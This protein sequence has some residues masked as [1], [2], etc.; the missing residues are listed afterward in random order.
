MS[1]PALQEKEGKKAARQ[2]ELAEIFKEA[3]PEMDL[4]KVKCIK[5]T[6]VD[7]AAHIAS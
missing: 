5:G 1:F 3:G 4:S 6:T 7:K 2:T